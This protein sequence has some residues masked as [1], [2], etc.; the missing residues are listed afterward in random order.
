MEGEDI[1]ELGRVGLGGGEEPGGG[2][3]EEEEEVLR[4]LH[5]EEGPEVGRGLA[6]ELGR[7]VGRVAGGIV[8]VL[9]GSTIGAEEREGERRE[10]G[11]D[12]E[13]K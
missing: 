11:R 2:V 5:G 12:R 13:I 4:G 7:E 6:L 1:G 9:V 3:E 10:E 8:L